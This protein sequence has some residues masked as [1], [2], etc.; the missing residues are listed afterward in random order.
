[1]NVDELID[2]VET[3]R[4]FVQPHLDRIFGTWLER[5][6]NT[7]NTDGKNRLIVIRVSGLMR[8]FRDEKIRIHPGRRRFVGQFEREQPLIFGRTLAC[9]F[10]THEESGCPNPLC[11]RHES[12]MPCCG[13]TKE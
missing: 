7:A 13:V 9:T 6:P 12:Q 2:P 1:M 10:R 8:V 5:L 11:I 4:P 3:H